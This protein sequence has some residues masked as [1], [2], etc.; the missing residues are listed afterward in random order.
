[1]GTIDKCSNLSAP[2]PDR[3][4]WKHLKAIVKDDECLENIVN[5][6]NA[7]IDLGHW[8]THF[9]LSLSIII[10]KPDKASYNSIKFFYSIILLNIL[11]KLI[12]KVIALISF[13]H[14]ITRCYL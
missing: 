7:C 2:G 8:P 3:I 12:K 10:P 4:S 14:S 11:E 6:A 13:H 9:K 5:I 1:M